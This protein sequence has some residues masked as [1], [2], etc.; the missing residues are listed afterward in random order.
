MDT[1]ENEYGLS[2]DAF[3]FAS[4]PESMGSVVL[5]SLSSPVHCEGTSVCV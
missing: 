1:A 5:Q 2:A 4:W 3:I